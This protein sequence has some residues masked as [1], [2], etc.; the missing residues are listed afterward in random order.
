M[1]RSFCHSISGDLKT[2]ILPLDKFKENVIDNSFEMPYS[3]FGAMHSKANPPKSSVHT[4][5]KNQLRS[6]DSLAVE[7]M[8]S[9]LVEST[10]GFHLIYLLFYSLKEKKVIFKGLLH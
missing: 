8:F 5:L 9:N 6:D 1:S 7:S 10:P 4:S 3:S 2:R